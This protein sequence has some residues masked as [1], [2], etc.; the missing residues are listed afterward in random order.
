MN[1][2]QV[3]VLQLQ[4]VAMYFI[5]HQM[6]TTLVL[7]KL[8]ADMSNCTAHINCATA[9]FLYF[10][11]FLNSKSFKWKAN[12]L[13]FFIYCINYPYV[14]YILSSWY[15]FLTCV[16]VL[17][18]QLVLWPADERRGH[19]ESEYTTILFDILYFP[20]RSIHFYLTN[21]IRTLTF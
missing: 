20:D 5:L 18:V 3:H 15:D 12:L 2:I 21:I 13:Y 8:L 9:R 7:Y 19:R 16:L 1:N 4:Y 11:I 14:Y 10:L 6:K 17:Y